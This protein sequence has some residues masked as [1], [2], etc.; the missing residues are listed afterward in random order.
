MRARSKQIAD[1]AQPKLSAGSSSRRLVHPDLVY[2]YQELLLLREKL[3][4]A[5]EPEGRVH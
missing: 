1:L 5:N 2:E 3:K 4:W